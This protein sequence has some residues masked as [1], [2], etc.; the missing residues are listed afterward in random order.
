MLRVSTAVT[1][2][3][4]LQ[5]QL[6]PRPRGR[7]QRRLE[8]G[9]GGGQ[10]EWRDCG[11]ADLGEHHPRPNVRGGE[12]ARGNRADDLQGSAGLCARLQ[13]QVEPDAAWKLLLLLLLLLLLSM[14]RRKPEPI[15]QR[16]D[17]LHCRFGTH[18]GLVLCCFRQCIVKLVRLP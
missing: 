6:R 11:A 10:G 4:E 3:F 17:F 9:D 12:R 14:W 8:Q 13:L 7:R 15:A 1:G 18:R 2:C 16:S 5:Q